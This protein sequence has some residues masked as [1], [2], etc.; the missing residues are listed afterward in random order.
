MF[1]VEPIMYIGIGFLAASLLALVT[2]PLV[3][4]RAVRLTLR[5][6]EADTPL[7]VVEVQAHKDQLRAKVAVT[8]CR[9][10]INVEELKA[11]VAKQLGELGK[12]ADTINRLKIE[13]AEK[14]AAIFALERSNNVL[15]AQL[16]AAEDV[17]LNGRHAD[18]LLANK[19]ASIT[20]DRDTRSILADSQRIEIVALKTEIQTLKERL[21]F[22][23]LSLDRS[24]SRQN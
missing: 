14:T 7:S 16:A 23:N 21:A 24:S 12:K 10:E 20:A 8:T 22:A 13:L 18:H 11:K 5:R 19:L 1:I 15:K 3:H 17:A 4:D 2:I 9:F 6:V